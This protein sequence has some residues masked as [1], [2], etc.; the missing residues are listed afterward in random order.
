MALQNYGGSSAEVRSIGFAQ[1]MASRIPPSTLRVLGRRDP[2]RAFLLRE[3]PASVPASFEEVPGAFASSSNPFAPTKAPGAKSWT[4]PKYSLRR[5][6]ALR[7]QANMLG[8]PTEALPPPFKS[9][10]ASLRDD[11][12]RPSV[13]ST[14]RSH[15]RIPSSRI[16]DEVQLEKKGPYAGRKGA[17]FKGKAWERN[18]DKRQ[19]ELKS[20]AEQADAK[21]AAWEQAK[22][23]EKTK[24]KVALPY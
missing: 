5:Q 11:A 15:P 7:R 19:Q 6:K 18:F 20:A 16:L 24:G 12:G 17:A 4:A 2:L 1:A 10:S 13:V 14:L 21:M 9:A 8:W 23:D 22:R 3:S